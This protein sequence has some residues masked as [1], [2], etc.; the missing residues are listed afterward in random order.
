M[1]LSCCGTRS[2]AVDKLCSRRLLQYGMVG[3]VVSLLRTKYI[4]T[5]CQ[6]Q[7]ASV[8]DVFAMSEEGP[9]GNFVNTHG[10]VHDMVTLRRAV[11]V[12]AVGSPEVENSW[13]KGCGLIAVDADVL[14]FCHV[15]TRHS[16]SGW[17]LSQCW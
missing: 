16:A 12:D 7:V 1:L 13:F 10:Y 14:V 4:E 6:V 3:A 2:L 15:S 5:L 11:H 9:A 17:P 8:A